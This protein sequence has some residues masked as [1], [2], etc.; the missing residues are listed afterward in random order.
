[1][2]ARGK[3]LRH[4]ELLARVDTIHAAMD[5]LIAVSAQR[6]TMPTADD[7]DIAANT[8]ANYKAEAK[9]WEAQCRQK[10]DALTSAIACES[11]LSKACAEWQAKAHEFEC[12]SK[13]LAE[14]RNQL[15]ERLETMTT[16]CDE[17]RTKSETIACNHSATVGQL[18]SQIDAWQNEAN[19]QRKR[20]DVW[21]QK[22]RDLHTDGRH[23][24]AAVSVDCPATKAALD[25]ILSNFL[26]RE[27]EADN[28]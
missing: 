26:E 1:M 8:K 6:A 24:Y 27:K 28:A 7:I 18:K 22:Y 25:A 9:F 14:A 3:I 21:Q 19:E 16:A 13:A 15:A 11:G 2:S 23:L 20:A 17:W 12:R 10:D 4:E 5:T